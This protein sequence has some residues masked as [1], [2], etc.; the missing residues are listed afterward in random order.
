M[1][2]AFTYLCYN[3]SVAFFLRKKTARGV[4]GKEYRREIFQEEDRRGISMKAE[5]KRAN[6]WLVLQQSLFTAFI[7][8]SMIE[9]THVG[10]GLIDG[11][12]VSRFLS[13][14]AMAASGIAH[15]IF[16]ITGIFGGLFATGM[17]TICCRKLGKGDVK[18]FNRVF[19]TV[20]YYGAVFSLA[21]TLAVQL[22]ARPLAILLGASGKGADLADLTA[23]YLR[24]VGMGLPAIVMSPVLTS[25]IQLDSG[26]KKVLAGTAICC[27][28]DILFDLL[29]VRMHA[30]MFGIG[31]A[32]AAAEYLQ[33]GFL[34][35]HFRTEDRMLRFVPPGMDRKELR[36]FFSSG[37]GKAL[38]RLGNVMR[39]V[40]LNYLIIFY[41]G[42]M[43]MTAM[44]VQNSLSS[45]THFLTVGLAE[46]TALMVGVLYGE[47]N[48]EGIRKAAAFVHRYCYIFC[49]SLCLLLLIFAWPVADLYIPVE[50][51]LL[52]LTAFAV[53]M[54]AL[55]TPLN[56]LVRSRISYLQATGKARLM[57]IMTG[58]AYLVNCLLCAGILGRLFGP[59]GIL[60]SCFVSDL[61][62]LAMVWVFHSLRV[63]KI[64]P[65]PE[66]YMD[67]SD[68]F[69]RSPGDVIYLDI[70]N[71]EDVSLVSE[72]IQLF[73]KGHRIDSRTG[74][75][76]A[77]CFEELA[78]NII[79]YGFPKAKNP[80]I[81]L[82][83]VYTPRELIL[84]LEDNCSP[85]DVERHIAIEVSHGRVDREK[86]LGLRILHGMA[87][88]ISYIHSLETN[89][90][91]LRFPVE[92]AG[93]ES[94]GT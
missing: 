26:R 25:A 42:T 62:T 20:M 2:F 49:G 3:R 34:F 85:F 14:D 38:R 50:G 46:A 88:N 90:V 81:D 56:A 36:E 68:N 61:V 69:H 52:A 79:D 82:R 51:P 39:P 7:T 8:F 53:R 80:G 72:Q 15:P 64:I 78:K 23:Q 33:A 58:L 92:Q 84:R 94:A 12:V 35:L 83:V 89:N 19:S 41:G 65:T 9:L 86:H 59:R 16:S 67:L 77:L 32:T 10:A 28:L 27:A 11:L 75:E 70:R 21:L 60:A 37:S 57:Q 91:I 63:H 17:Q 74:Y 22:L 43:A 44:S 55:Q 87:H 47:I 13:A 73:C 66:D 54:I 76:A 40:L 24:G 29:A 93:S 71:Q 30:G 6:R 18:G 48:D 1:S 31:F 5:K 4:S 45:F